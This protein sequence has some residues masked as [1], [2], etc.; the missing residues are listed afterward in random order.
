M[1][2][3]EIA[4]EL[5]AQ[6][7]SFLD[8]NSVY[9]QAKY[10]PVCRLVPRETEKGGEVFA[11][12][13]DNEGNGTPTEGLIDDTYPMC[14]YHRCLS[15]SF[16]PFDEAQRDS[17]GS[18]VFVKSTAN[19][20][21]VVYGDASRL[22]VGQERLVGNVIASMPSQLNK[23]FIQNYEG[24]KSVT[25]IPTSENNDMI[26]VYKNEGFK[27]Y[28]LETNMLLFSVNYQIVTEFDKNCYDI[29]YC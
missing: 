6:I 7:K 27:Q 13:V 10:Y 23:T 21:M 14:I 25:I 17:F 20:L 19:M 22:K 2:T 16:A 26:A 3:N 4:G 29:C 18:R 12:L 1:F 24:L 8:H 11:A 28:L 9:Q 5:N 15:Y